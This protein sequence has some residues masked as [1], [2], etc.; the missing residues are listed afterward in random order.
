M[1]PIISLLSCLL[2]VSVVDAATR[3]ALVS[4]CGGEAGA[5]VLALAQTKL[6]TEPEIVL[7]ERSEVERVLR[8]QKLWRC[9]LSSYDQA[10]AAGRLLGVEVFAALEVLPSQKDS[11]GLVCFAADSG[12]RLMDVILPTG[13]ASTA[14]SE[15]LTAVHEACTKQKQPSTGYNTVCILSVRNAGLSRGLDGVC[16]SVGR[17]LE[18]RLLSSP[19]LAVLERARL[20][21]INREHSLPTDRNATNGLTASMMLLELEFT[22]GAGSNDIHVLVLQSNAA[23]QSLGK[24]QEDAHLDRT[25]DLADSLSVQLVRSMKANPMRQHANRGAESVRFCLEATFFQENGQVT[26]AV[27]AAEAAVAL[28]P[29]NTR[30]QKVLAKAL[31]TMANELMGP[32]SCRLFS[33]YKVPTDRLK[34]VLGLGLRGGQLCVDQ[35]AQLTTN[36]LSKSVFPP[37]SA[38]EHALYEVLVRV[39]NVVEGYDAESQA[40]CTELRALYRHLQVDLYQNALF[41]ELKANPSRNKDINRFLYWHL[42]YLELSSSTSAQWTTDALESLEFWLSLV[43]QQEMCQVQHDAIPWFLSAELHR[44][45]EPKRMVYDFR[46]PAPHCVYVAFRPTIMPPDNEGQFWVLT[47]SDL[48]RLAAF[49]IRLKQHPDPLLQLYGQAGDLATMLRREPESSATVR[50]QLDQVLRLGMA[51]IS[52]PSCSQ[53][54]YRE[55]M[56]QALLDVIDLVN[57]PE[58]RQAKLTE[59]FNFMLQRREFDYWVAMAA[60]EPNTPRYFPHNQIGP[61]VLFLSSVP[62]PSTN[63]IAYA[64]NLERLLDLVNSRD[65]HIVVDTPKSWRG[66]LDQQLAKLRERFAA[67][68]PPPDRKALPW[69]AA[70]LLLSGAKQHL[71]Q[72]CVV[73]DSVWVLETDYPP[74]AAMRLLRVPLDGGKVEAYDRVPIDG[75]PDKH[76]AV[77]SY[78]NIRIF[79]ADDI[80]VS[81]LTETNGLPSKHVS[82]LTC[83]D[84]KLYAGIGYDGENTPSYLLKC[85]LKTGRM[86]VLASSLRREAKS[87]LDGVMPRFIIRQMLA[88]PV[89][90]RVLFTAD[91]G[92]NLL[93]SGFTGLWGLDTKTDKLTLLMK[94]NSPCEWISPI[95]GN[96]I[97][98]A[99]RCQLSNG[100]YS[101]ISFNLE[102]NKGRILYTSTWSEMDRDLVEGDLPQTIPYGVY[103]PHLIVDGWLWTA[104]PFSR[105]L[106]NGVPRE[107][108]PSFTGQSLPAVGWQSGFL[109]P[110][111][112]WQSGFLEP[113]NNGRQI[114][115]GINNQLWLLTLPENTAKELH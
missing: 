62:A 23:G 100:A 17:M 115:A 47:D 16:E 95:R 78:G 20:E 96:Q 25:G 50:A 11:L 101:V 4:T 30:A 27:Q 37:R 113:I 70:K 80:P 81:H 56:Y 10:V 14:V 73:G 35:I 83:C 36:Q 26:Q 88:D 85:D 87:P 112:G 74:T 54:E 104:A 46:E 21:Q 33:L 67:L 40:E 89:R 90:Q 43:A 64:H 84:G 71:E 59:L 111:T 29:A 79:P 93:G 86:D 66:P 97:L 44:L 49:F 102:T 7:V 1:R 3:V 57:D 110:S 114:L 19:N 9:G 105:I 106:T 98:L 45:R 76:Y 24:I 41:A 55:G 53:T 32:G 58:L 60:V 52:A 48:A 6:A 77:G 15:I 38:E 92:I 82:A 68:M 18:R 72:P 42:S 63:N 28:A 12:A 109:N 2:C 13:D 75:L 31:L 65:F 91:A 5:D 94:L 22:P 39:R 69:T 99:R 61:S 51:G 107:F 108:F 103:A 8:E 34:Q